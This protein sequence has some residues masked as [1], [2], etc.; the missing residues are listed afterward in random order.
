MPRLSA[1]SIDSGVRL[2]TLCHQRCSSLSI[3]SVAME[4]ASAPDAAPPTPSATM[5]M[6]GAVWTETS[7]GAL[8]VAMSP[9]SRF[10]IKKES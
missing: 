7:V 1:A 3:V 5:R 10:A 8:I 4:L 2:G 9:V 6:K